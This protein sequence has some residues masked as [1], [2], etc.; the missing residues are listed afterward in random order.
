[1]TDMAISA[2]CVQSDSQPVSSATTV[3][4]KM[5]IRDKMLLAFGLMAAMSVFSGAIALW[6]NSQ[7]SSRLHSITQV[8]VPAITF[9]QK[10]AEEVSRAIGMGPA[11][12]GAS[13]PE[14]LAS[15]KNQLQAQGQVLS[16]LVDS[17]SQAG[18]PES[19]V[20]Q[21]SELVT[22]MFENYDLTANFTAERLEGRRRI[23]NLVDTIAGAHEDMLRRLGPLSAAASEGLRKS[24]EQTR[25]AT[26]RTVETLV[27]QGVGDLT[28]VMEVRTAM[29]EAMQSL[30]AATGART[31]AQVDENRQ[32]LARALST[33]TMGLNALHERLNTTRVS[34]KV[35]RVI[36]IGT[37][38]NNP[39]EARQKALAAGEPGVGSKTEDMLVEATTLDGD[40]RKMIDALA[41][42]ARATV[43]MTGDDLRKQTDQALTEMVNVGV[44]QV[45]TH[46]R[47]VAVLNLMVGILNEAASTQDAQRLDVLKARFE[48][49]RTRMLELIASLPPEGALNQ[50]KREFN[51]LVAF[52]MNDSGLFTTNASLLKLEKTIQERLDQ[53]GAL[54]EDIGRAVHDIVEVVR[55]NTD[56]ATAEADA[57]SARGRLI[58]LILAVVSV[59]AAGGIVQIYVVPRMVTPIRNI[60]HMMSRLADGDLEIDVPTVKS[61][62][63]IAE[64]TRT[65]EVFK[66]NAIERQRLADREKVE[67]E[68]TLQRQKLV[69]QHT[70]QFDQVVT[71]MISQVSQLSTSLHSA[72]DTLTANAQR[73]ERQSVTALSSIREASGNIEAVSAAAS[74]LLT[75]ISDI[76]R[77]VAESTKISTDAEHETQATNEKIESLADAVKRISEVTNLI[78]SIATQTN[79]LALNATIE[80]ARAGE[81]G[82]GFAVVA[83]EVKTLANQTAKATGDIAI[84]IASI[85]AETNEAVSAIRSITSII[86]RMREVGTAIS[87]AVEEQGAATKEIV[88]NVEQAVEGTSIVMS[89]ITT[90][91]G[92]A[93]ETGET[94]NLVL[95]S[96]TALQQQSDTLRGEIEGFLGKVQ[97]I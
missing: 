46:G 7:I 71:T 59:I 74:Q 19:H 53:S 82:K 21:L 76:G 78:N 8:N 96:A 27:N 22:K 16:S 4:H 58:L 29:I 62:D 37:G 28:T 6:S 50:V 40:L 11:L 20:R 43:V 63:E 9:T 1:M 85:Q 66:R 24:P 51:K 23:A 48:E 75:S 44:L 80:A 45:E 12:S 5:G 79:L 10:L 38:P 94:A 31:T 89:N 14:I 68:R 60:T 61:R 17:L 97:A 65:L 70:Q 84:Q 52:G 69:S 77:Q 15:A 54:A 87:A 13:S 55:H 25:T 92:D 49:N 39:F 30:H 32:T 36:E 83:N 90:L 33:V 93:V 2:D 41:N 3:Q 72:S 56:E 86:G 47:L 42:K 81:A 18:V 73:T 57:V 35:A 91:A 95:S 88:R 34:K 26:N 67:A 64:I